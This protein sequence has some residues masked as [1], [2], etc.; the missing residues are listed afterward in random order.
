MKHTCPW[1]KQRNDQYHLEEIEQVGTNWILHNELLANEKWVYDGEATHVGQVI[2]SHKIIIN[3]CPY[4]GEKLNQEFETHQTG[5]HL[6]H[7]PPPVY[8][9]PSL[10]NLFICPEN[11][12]HNLGSLEK[13]FVSREPDGIWMLEEYL[14]EAM[15]LN[16]LS[17]FDILVCPFCG[18]SLD[19]ERAG[20]FAD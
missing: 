6:K 13:W 19:K 2:Y 12:A 4:C 18:E 5:F 1:I 15:E 3:F 10:D 9:K 16:F 8:P 20:I 11:E 14:P 17:G 7:A